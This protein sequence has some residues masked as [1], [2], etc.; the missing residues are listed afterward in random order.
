MISFE[1]VAEACFEGEEADLLGLS[2][3]ENATCQSQ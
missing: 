2:Q 3:N 1:S